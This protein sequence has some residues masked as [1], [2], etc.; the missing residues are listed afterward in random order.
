MA[1]THQVAQGECL[2]SIAADYRFSD[3]RTIYN[4]PENAELRRKRQNPN[5]VYPGDLI[6]IPH[7]SLGKV[8]CATGRL[9]RFVLRKQL[10][11]LRIAIEDVEGNP[12]SGKKYRLEVEGETYEGST[13]G[14]GLLEKE[15]PA[16]AKSGALTVWLDDDE[17]DDYTWELAIGALDPIEEISGVQARLNNLGYSCGSVDGIAGP[18]T[19]AAVKEFQTRM[20]LPATAIIDDALRKKL[21][22]AYDED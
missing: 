13:A 12:L 11:L 16:T 21:R 22:Q 14:E 10:T 20:S 2:A 5:L 15:I 3:W 7:L 19:K 18:R 8:E 4:R 1:L 6:Y 9:H 17:Y